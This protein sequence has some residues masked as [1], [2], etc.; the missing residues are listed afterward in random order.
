[1]TRQLSLSLT[2]VVLGSLCLATLPATANDLVYDNGPISNNFGAFPISGPLATAIADSFTVG[3][4]SP[5]APSL[6]SFGAWTLPGDEVESVDL[7]LST[8]AVGGIVLFDQVVPLLGTDCS[9]N[10]SGYNVCLE[11]TI[12]YFPS[13]E[14]GT[15]WITLYDA[16]SRDSG[17]VGWDVNYGI[18]CI[19]PGCPSQAQNQQGDQLP[20]ESFAI[21]SSPELGAPEPG[22]LLLL[23]SGIVGTAGAARRKFQR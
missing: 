12:G 22:S 19:S 17:V 3:G 2:L 21:Y 11:S 15:Y 1:M 14:P 10:P 5:V 16:V 13:L 23:A 18:G 6:I 7:R 8:Q 20:S 9:I 4:S